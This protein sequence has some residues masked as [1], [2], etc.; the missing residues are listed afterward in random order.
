MINLSLYRYKPDP[1]DRPDENPDPGLEKRRKLVNIV[2]GTLG[3]GSGLGGSYYVARKYPGTQPQKLIPKLLAVTTAG[4]VMGRAGAATYNN[5]FNRREHEKPD[6]EKKA[7]ATEGLDNLA[8]PDRQKSLLA[9][10]KAY[11]DKTKMGI[12]ESAEQ[13]KLYERMALS[14]G[15][16]KKASLG[17]SVPT[18]IKQSG[19]AEIARMRARGRHKP[20]PYMH[21]SPSSSSGGNACPA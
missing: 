11:V 19:Y 13:K 8:I 20:K 14:L 15:G 4:Y 3:L 5:I 7:A 12:A 9:I 17:L 18:V 10:S 2:G 1:N 16:I 21:G 6:T